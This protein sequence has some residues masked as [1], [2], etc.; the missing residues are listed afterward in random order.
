MIRTS[1]LISAMRD[2][3][4]EPMPLLPPQITPDFPLEIL[5][6]YLRRVV[7]EVLML[8]LA[9]ASSIVG[10]LLCGLSASVQGL[11]SVQKRAHQLSPVSLAMLFSLD[12]GERKSSSLALLFSGIHAFEREN[13]KIDLECLSTYQSQF[14]AWECINSGLLSAIRSK[15]KNQEDAFHLSQELILHES[16]R[17]KCGQSFALFLRRHRSLLLSATWLKVSKAPH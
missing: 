9:P 10:G 1:E 8:S 2:L 11:I 14:K 5:P 4:S 13:V 17:P 7:V 12:S 6:P 16:M 15:T 3:A